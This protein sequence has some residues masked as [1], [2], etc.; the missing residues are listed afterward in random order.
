MAIPFVDLKTQYE[1]LG[2][3][4]YARI[5]R[6]LEHGKYIMGPEVADLEETLAAYVGIKHALGCSSGTDGLL[7]ALMA[8][9]VG[10]GDAAFTTPFT[11]IASAEVIS[12]LGATPVFVDIDPDLDPL[13]LDQAP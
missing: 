8:L 12:L 4:I 3:E 9:E 1:R 2:P 13:A 10:P 6:V 11:F 7:M 5:Q